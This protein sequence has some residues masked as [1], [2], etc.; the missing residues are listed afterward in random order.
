MEI[1]I[2]WPH[3]QTQDI[4]SQPC[5]Q[6]QDISSQPRDQP[7]DISV[8]P[9][10]QPQDI[11][12][13]PRDQPQDISGQ[14]RDQPQDIS[15]QPRNQPQ[16]I[17]GQPRDQ[18]Q[19]ISGQPRDQPQDISVQPRDQPQDISGQPRDQPQDISG[20]PRNQPQ[21]ISVQPRD[22]PQDIYVQPRDQPQDIS[23]Q[24]RDQPQDISVQPRDQPQDISGQPR[25]QP[26][27]ISGQPRDQ[28]QDISG[29][30]RDQPQDISVQPRDQPQD[31]SGQPRDQPQDISGQPRDQPQDIS[32][33]PR[34]QPQDI[35]GQPR[36]QPQ[37]IS[38]Q[39]RDQPQDISGQPRDQP[40]DI[41]GQPR[42]Q[43]QD[44]SVQP[45]DQ[46][47]D[48]SVQPRDQ[49]QDISVQPRNQPQ[50]ISV[51]PCDQPQDI[52]RQ[53]HIS[54]DQPPPLVIDLH[55]IKLAD[56]EESIPLYEVEEYINMDG[57]GDVVGDIESSDENLDDL[58]EDP[59]WTPEKVDNSEEEMEEEKGMSPVYDYPCLQ[60]HIETL[61]PDKSAEV[62]SAGIQT[63]EK[64]AEVP[65]EETI[66]QQSLSPARRTVS[67]GN[68]NSDKEY[69]NIFIKKYRKHVNKDSKHGRTYDTVH[70]CLF[71]AK[72]MTNISI[73]LENNHKREKEV[74][75]IKLLKSQIEQAEGENKTAL[76]QKKRALQDILRNK[77][78][79][80]H[81]CKVLQLKDGE[82][83]LSRRKIS[84]DFDVSKY[85]PCID[86]REWVLLD[87]LPQHK[88][89]C[90]VQ[91]LHGR[92]EKKTKGQLIMESKILTGV[93]KTAG[94]TKLKKDVFPTMQRDTITEIAQNDELIIA[95]GDV[96]LMKNIGNKL[97][98]NSFTSFRMRL[99]A[100]LLLLLR[101][102]SGLSTT[103]V[104]DYIKPEQFDRVVSCAIKCCDEDEHHEMKTPS[105]A[106]KL[107]YDL[108]R[109]AYIKQSFGIKGKDELMKTEAADFL[110]LYHM[111]WSVKVS[112]QARV[113]LDERHFNKKAAL[114]N[115][116]DIQKLANY[117]V[118]SLTNLD[119]EQSGTT[120]F[121]EIAVLTE[122]RL[123]L[124]NRRRPREL[125][126]LRY[127]CIFSFDTHTFSQ[128]LLGMRG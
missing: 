47:Q 107:G 3:D 104:T 89:C 20:Q 69:P 90:P 77:G 96:W 62:S 25:D 19:D 51:Q 85:G 59:D 17:S 9:R 30:P 15:V 33:Q 84:S 128:L 76:V 101:E 82:V 2:H 109:L 80:L 11:S 111:E 54:D 75:E 5:D 93:I 95:L 74:E 39:P 98:R 94:S 66:D 12:G 35:S 21:D 58:E 49:P 120:V 38:V 52:S 97:R 46:P 64:S 43:P 22:Q 99:A 71:C 110:K 55:L 73:H 6:P 112:K 125:E 4:S 121:R 26:Q 27:D 100:R 88:L 7:Q 29:Q 117:L 65:S 60:K 124:Y 24:P 108:A 36:D 102:D 61:T 16:D 119:L 50:D 116:A 53:R 44:I 68:R 79:D 42:D 31:I 41:S 70:A 45:H 87:C 105:T 23:G 67:P 8:Q 13:Q 14:P 18:P 10:D 114:P 83:L 118:Q 122:A 32:V 91:N 103:S 28:P 72:L 126:S 115:P 86:C 92:E 106:I 34:D 37:D 81:N 113:I 78:D 1:A 48:I 56:F 123:L 57:T 40:Q 63:P 127:C